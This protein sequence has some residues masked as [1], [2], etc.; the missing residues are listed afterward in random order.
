MHVLAIAEVRKLLRG[1][2]VAV[3]AT[4]LE[5]NAA[6]WS[7]THKDSGEDYQAYLRRLLV[8]QGVENPTAEDVRRFDRDRPKKKGSKE[9]WPAPADPDSRIAK[10]K[11]GTTHLA[12]K[13]EYVVDLDLEFVRAAPVYTADQPG[14]GDA[15]R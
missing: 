8:E 11:D 6:M 13:A 1:K 5:A 4:T 10:M 2:T 9:E 7:I 14:S 15:R 12:Y 3:N